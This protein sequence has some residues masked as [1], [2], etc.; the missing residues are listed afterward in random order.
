V[1][2][3]YPFLIERPWKKYAATLRTGT[4]SLGGTV[5]A[6]PGHPA[7]PYG[8]KFLAAPVSATPG[9]S[10]SSA[11]RGGEPVL[12]AVAFAAL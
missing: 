3:L 6:R 8:V 10:D 9:M 2:M 5:P 1:R 7:W 4:C 11:V 12:C